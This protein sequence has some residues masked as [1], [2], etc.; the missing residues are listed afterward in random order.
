MKTNKQL[1]RKALDF[2]KEF[3]V[4]IDISSLVIPERQKGFDQLI[5]I[6]VNTTRQDLRSYQYELYKRQL[7]K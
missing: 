6:P 3:R 4:T 5:L 1:L 7:T 2:W